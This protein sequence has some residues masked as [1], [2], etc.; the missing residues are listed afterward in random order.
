MSLE[1][2]GCLPFAAV[3]YCWGDPKGTNKIFLNRQPYPVTANLYAFL[4]HAQSILSAI[5]KF[6]P[7]VLRLGRQESV[8][9]TQYIVYS[10]LQ[11]FDFPL[12][13]PSTSDSTLSDL[14]K[15]HVTKVVGEAYDSHSSEQLHSSPDLLDL[16]QIPHEPREPGSCYLR[17][18]IDAL[19]INQQDLH[20]RS[21]QVG[22]MRNIYSRATSLLIWPQD[23]STS[24]SHTK[25]VAEFAHDIHNTVRPCLDGIIGWD[26][27]VSQ[28]TSDGFLHPRLQSIERF[29]QIIT[30][31]WFRRM[32]IIQEVATATGHA[33]ALLGFYP[34]QWR[35]LTHIVFA[36]CREMSNSDSALRIMFLGD[37]K[38][39]SILQ[40]L[41]REYKEL[42][43]KSE[44]SQE[45]G[46]PIKVPERLRQLL[47]QTGGHFKATEP[48]DYLY[49]L[50]GLLGTN[51]IPQEI[52]PDYSM[53]FEQ[54]FHNYAI[55]LIK[56]TRDISFLISHGRE[57]TGVP[58]WVPDWRFGSSEG[59]KPSPK[60]IDPSHVEVSEDGSCLE[61]DGIILGKIVTVVHPT[62]IEADIRS[63]NFFGRLGSAEQ[64]EDENNL[65]TTATAILTIFRG[66]QKLKD[67][68]F[69]DLMAVI[70]GISFSNFKHHWEGFWGVYHHDIFRQIREML[71]GAREVDLEML[72]KDPSGP[73][74]VT[75][76]LELLDM[77]VAGLGILD[78]SGMVMSSRTK[79][80]IR[81][82]DIICLFNGVYQ[83]CI[84]HRK[85]PHYSFV[86]TCRMSSFQEDIAEE[87]S[88]EGYEVRRLVLV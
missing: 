44:L 26:D 62:Q 60:F 37:A 49:A 59:E 1:A 84:L 41:E 87:R 11:D 86:S 58:S 47:L 63:T 32:W 4:Q 81:N 8:L 5:T 30:Q 83:P 2:E 51:D 71:E 75:I 45:T 85:G 39:L 21:Q 43:Q 33:T 15:R 64:G 28:I 56:N 24:I 88:F 27:V 40:Q 19:C 57:I 77:S 53:P 14:V 25:A 73:I 74:M 31:R 36:C 52:Y 9:I 46:L 22:R 48:H 42:K 35:F 61:V 80:S 17:L 50:L 54:V 3:S 65:M 23:T 68:C 6:L 34:V 67:M 76:G 55:Y 66:M 82:D 38:C 13:F 7:V 78:R 18:W 70:P 79:E 29:R 20:E 10:I 72:I 69:R 12:D 16:F